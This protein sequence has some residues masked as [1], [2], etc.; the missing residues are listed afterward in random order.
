MAGLLHDTGKLIMASNNPEGYEQALQHS[1]EIGIVAAEEE[2]FGFNHADIG[3][4]LFALWGLPV[5][6]VNAVEFH[7]EPLKSNQTEVSILVLVHAADAIA[8]RQHEEVMTPGSIRVDHSY[9]DSVGLKD[10]YRN[11]AVAYAESLEGSPVA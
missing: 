6:I 4:Y 9:L 1:V 7:H 8:N 10:H 11:W 3:G 5:S 2:V